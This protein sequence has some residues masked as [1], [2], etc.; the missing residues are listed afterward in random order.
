MFEKSPR[1]I[2]FLQRNSFFSR[3]IKQA[4]ATKNKLIRVNVIDHDGCFGLQNTKPREIPSMHRGVINNLHESVLSPLKKFY[5]T[6]LSLVSYNTTLNL[7]HFCTLSE[8]FYINPENI[9]RY[10]YTNNYS[11]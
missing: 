7:Y 5:S 8:S 1:N 3:L 11:I 10:L 2:R 9:E 4:M 6:Y